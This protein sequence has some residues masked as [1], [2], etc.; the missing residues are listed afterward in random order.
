MRDGPLAPW[1]STLT[2]SLCCWPRSVRARTAPR[3]T[4]RPMDQ[5]QIICNE[6]LALLVGQTFRDFA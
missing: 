6:N 1:S 4:Y 3:H 5:Q 2:T